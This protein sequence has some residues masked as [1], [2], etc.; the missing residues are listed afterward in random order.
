VLLFLHAKSKNKK[1]GAFASLGFFP[2]SRLQF[3]T[4]A[5]RRVSGICSAQQF[6]CSREGH[7]NASVT[8]CAVGFRFHTGTWGTLPG[9]PRNER[10]QG[11]FTE[12]TQ[13]PTHLRGEDIFAT[14]RCGTALNTN[15]LGS[16]G[17]SFSQH[18]YNFTEKF[19]S[20]TQ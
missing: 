2:V 6:C 8:L 7:T 10:F 18:M 5:L 4:K 15:L 17:V 1:A 20:W 14:A 13:P 9:A 3:K 12:M 11:S 16:A 19:K